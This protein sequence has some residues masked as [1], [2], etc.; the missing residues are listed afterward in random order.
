MTEQDL[1][2][3]AVDV[4]MRPERKLEEKAVEKEIA[5]TF[6]FLKKLAKKAKLL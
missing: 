1:F 3:K 5:R 6:K 2:L 4:T